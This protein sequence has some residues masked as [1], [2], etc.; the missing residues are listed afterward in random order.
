VPDSRQHRGAHPDDARD[1]AA[2]TTPLLRAAVRDLSYLLGHAYA[3]EAA[4]K[5]VGDRYQLRARQRSAVLRCSCSDAAREGRSA[6][7]R[8]A[9]QLAE[10]ALAVDGFNC[11]ISVE[12]MLSGAPILRGRDGALRDLA[13]V[14]GTYRS[15]AETEAAAR[16]AL[17]NVQRCHVARVQLM[18]DR[19]VGNSG[20]TRALLLRCA[21]ELNLS[22]EVTLSDRVD[23]E[24]AAFPGIVASSDSWIL[25]RAQHW[26]D[27]PALVAE[28]EALPL[29]LLD[30]A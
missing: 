28:A 17:A 20:R 10:Q 25:D 23:A 4:L 27:L 14:H 1:F 19:P 29:W 16:L 3:E 9:D 8:Y 18:L 24:L 7:R 15:V 21:A 6:R 11:L 13:S 30:F 22:L 12:A 26:I 5:L 2:E